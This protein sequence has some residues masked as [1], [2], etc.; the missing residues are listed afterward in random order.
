MVRRRR[1]GSPLVREGRVAAAAGCAAGAGAVATRARG[2]WQRCVARLRVGPGQGGIRVSNVEGHAGQR[3]LGRRRR[4][5]VSRGRS[6]Y[7][8]GPLLPRGE[9]AQPALS[10][11]PLGLG[12]GCELEQ[13]LL[14]GTG[15]VLGGDGDGKLGA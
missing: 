8:R 5:R 3:P 7:G 12:R 2:R 9:P 15:G 1:A 6:P 10:A 14:R 4:R 11:L 13:G